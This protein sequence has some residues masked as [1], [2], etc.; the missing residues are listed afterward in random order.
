M[1]RYFYQKLISTGSSGDVTTMV[2]LVMMLMS[3]VIA[4]MS[5]MQTGGLGD[6]IVGV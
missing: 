2:N 3:N 4:A 1:T 6:E 5:M